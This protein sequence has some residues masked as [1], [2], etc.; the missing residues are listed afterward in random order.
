M[1]NTDDL[2]HLN[3]RMHYN[4]IVYLHEEHIIMVHVIEFHKKN[5]EV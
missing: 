5:F 3:F 2:K 4:L 1:G